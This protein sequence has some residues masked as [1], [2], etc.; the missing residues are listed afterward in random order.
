[1]A[2]CHTCPTRGGRAGTAASAS[3]RGGGG[4]RDCARVR[5]AG[6]RD[7][8]SSVHRR[9]VP[10]HQRHGASGPGDAVCIGNPRSHPCPRRRSELRTARRSDAG[11]GSE[12]HSCIPHASALMSMTEPRGGGGLQVLT[13]VQRLLEGT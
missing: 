1:M 7:R 13:Q 6:L 12:V 5:G 2:S 8:G 9:R 3:V 10:Q 11:A 4:G